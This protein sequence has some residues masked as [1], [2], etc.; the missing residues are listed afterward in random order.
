MILA[1]RYVNPIY[2][3]DYLGNLS[4]TALS[5]EV[6]VSAGILFQIKWD[7][8]LDSPAKTKSYIVQRIINDT[9]FYYCNALNTIPSST[10]NAY[11]EAWIVHKGDI[12]PE[13]PKNEAI[14]TWYQE[15]NGRY[16]SAGDIVITSVTKLV[17]RSITGNLGDQS[18]NTGN[19]PGAYA[20]KSVWKK[21]SYN[22]MS[23]KISS[24]NNKPIWWDGFIPEHE[25]IATQKLELEW[26]FCGCGRKYELKLNGK[27]I[28]SNPFIS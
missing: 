10:R 18:Q 13:S 8:V 21:D 2:E 17:P 24:T 9:S 3:T 16:P 7:I 25:R 26:D 19:Y 14:D 23:G 22:E 15:Y 4:M 27:T 5:Q 12:R 20:G 28:I 6:G 11:W 1:Y